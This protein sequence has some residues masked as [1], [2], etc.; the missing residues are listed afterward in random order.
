MREW[1]TMPF[2]PAS[3]SGP[4][5]VIGLA[6]CRRGPSWRAARLAITAVLRRQRLQRSATTI[7]TGTREGEQHT[8]AARVGCYEFQ[9]YFVCGGFGLP[10]ICLAR[11]LYFSALTPAQATEITKNMISPSRCLLPFRP[12]PPR[13]RACFRCSRWAPSRG[14]RHRRQMP[15]RAL[16]RAPLQRQRGARERRRTRHR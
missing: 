12:V 16:A 3:A 14:E 13:K 4:L 8:F 1:A 5:F 7:K 2:R 10:G 11:H 9:S 15:R 6:I